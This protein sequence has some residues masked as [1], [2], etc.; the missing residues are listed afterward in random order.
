MAKTAEQILNQAISDFDSIEAAI[1]ESGVDVPYGTDTSEYGNLVRKAVALAQSG[2]QYAGDGNSIVVD[3]N[4][5]IKIVGIDDAQS[6]A[7]LRKGEN[8]EIEWIVPSAESTEDLAVVVAELSSDV[9]TLRDDVDALEIAVSDKAN[10][11]DV[12]TKTEVDGLIS[13]GGGEYEFATD[14]EVIALLN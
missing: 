7:Y 8:G 12:Y 5:I 14:E 4:N 6:G 1:E 3:E 11:D 9:T 2:N 10:A 13:T